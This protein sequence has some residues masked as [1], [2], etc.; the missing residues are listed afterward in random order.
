MQLRNCMGNYSDGIYPDNNLSDGIC[1]K[2]IGPKKLSC[3]SS[4]F[5]HLL[6]HGPKHSNWDAFQNCHFRNSG[7]IQKIPSMPLNEDE[8]ISP[9][10]NCTTDCH[11][12]KFACDCPFYMHNQGQGLYVTFEEKL[13]HVLLL[14]GKD[15]LQ[16]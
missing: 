9:S 14:P 2:R 6:H 7:V 12:S 3:Y 13:S 11:N 16:N 15:F 10:F 5:I 4:E 1:P 8:R